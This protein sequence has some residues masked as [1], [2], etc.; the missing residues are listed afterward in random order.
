MS[1]SQTFEPLTRDTL[2]EHRQ[3]HFFLDQVL[4]SLESLATPPTDA[5]PLRRLAAQLQGLAE[6]MAEHN[7]AE[8]RVG[9]WFQ[10]ILESLP[11]KRV[12]I[13][14]LTNEHQRFVEILEMARLHAQSCE[15][16]DASSLRDDLASYLDAFRRHEHAEETLLRLAIERQATALD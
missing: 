9:G 2:E 11:D 16:A 7:Q 12:E 3:I 1:D 5:E 15:P 13:D 8:E 14:R 10:A 6:R 4:A